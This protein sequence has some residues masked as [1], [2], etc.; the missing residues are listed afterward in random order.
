VYFVG[1]CP[2]GIILVSLTSFA[3]FCLLLFHLLVFGLQL[4]RVHQEEIILAQQ[5]SELRFKPQIKPFQFRQGRGSFL[6][7]VQRDLL[8]RQVRI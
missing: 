7:E 4:R 8:K 6:E 2:T 3:H 1:F 5:D